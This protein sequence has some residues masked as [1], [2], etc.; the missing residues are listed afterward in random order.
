MRQHPQ[1]REKAALQEQWR[2]APGVCGVD[3]HLRGQQVQGQ[4][5]QG[6]HRAREQAPVD[7]TWGETRP[8]RQPGSA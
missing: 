3:A 2:E 1:S 5:Q 8:H 6:A 7:T 4:R